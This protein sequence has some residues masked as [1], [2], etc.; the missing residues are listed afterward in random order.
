[1]VQKQD[2]T[3]TLRG[4]IT[5][6]RAFSPLRKTTETYVSLNLA[7]VDANGYY[8]SEAVLNSE[9]SL[10]ADT[11]GMA[12]D[13]IKQRGDDA[14]LKILSGYCAPRKQEPKQ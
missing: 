4:L 9:S 14:V 5:S 8:I 10:G 13:L 1:V 11:L 3:L 6:R 2:A 7:L 12:L